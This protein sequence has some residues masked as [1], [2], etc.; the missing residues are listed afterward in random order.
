MRIFAA[1]F[2][3]TALNAQDSSLVQFNR[4]IRPLLSDRCFACHGPDPGNRKSPLRLDREAD[5]KA[6]LGK[7]RYGIVP[8]DPIRSGIYQRITSAN[9]G[10][11]MP[12]AYAGHDALPAE[13]IA[14]IKR[15][16]EQGAPYQAHYSFI[17]P[18]RPPIP[19]A[20]RNAI[21]HFIQARLQREGLAPAPPAD[22]RTLMRRVTLDL[23]GLPPTPAEMESFL[24]DPS[25][26][27]YEKV[28]DRL[29]ASPRYAERMAIRW[30]EAARYADTNGYQSDGTRDMWRWRDWVIDAFRKNMPFDQF[31]VEQ[32]A[33]DLLPNA[34]LSQRIATG[35]QRNHRT[36]AEGGI[37]DE[38]F[39]VEYV[40]DRTETTSTV[41]LGLTLGCARCHDHKFDPLA[42]KD[43]YSMFAFYNNVP[44]RGFVWN[45]G[46]E[47][48][49]I[50]APSPAEKAKLDQ[51]D[52]RIAQQRAKV[53]ALEPAIAKA[54]A[55]WAVPDKIWQVND[56]L[57]LESTAGFACKGQ[58]APF[59]GQSSLERILTKDAPDKPKFNNQDPFTFAAWIRPEDGKGAILSRAEDEWEGQQHGLYVVDGKLRL[60]IVFRWSDLGSRVETKLPLKL[61]QWQH[62]SA[63]YDGGMR[64][65]GIHLYVDGIEQPVNVL[66]D[67]LVWPIENK[68]PWRIGAGASLRF[69][70]EIEQPL[71]YSRALTSEEAGTLPLKQTLA[72]LVALKTK[73]AQS[74]LRMAFLELGLP[75]EL[76]RER[77]ALFSLE[78]ERGKY[79]ETVPTVM[80]M[81]EGATRQA[82]VLKRGAYDQHGEPVSPAI[83]A[84]LPGWQP[85]WPKNRLGLARWIVSRQNPLTARVTVNR[86]WQML[87]GTGIVKTVEDFGSQ[88]EWPLHMELLDWLA[89]EFMENGWDTKALLKTIVTSD[90]YR[91]SS[92]VSP[93]LLA[94]DPENRL[95]ARGTRLRISPEMVRDQALA[96]SGLLVDRVGG[97]SVKPYQP[98]GLWQEL[99]GGKGYTPDAG[100]GLYRRSLYT[101]WKRTIAP[102]GMV[103]FD[104]PTR[105]L[106]IVREG[107]TN[108]PLQALNLMN[109]V[110]YLEA[111]RKLAERML[112]AS[113]AAEGRLTYAYQATLGRAPKAAELT[114]LMRTLNQF[115]RQYQQDPQAAGE[116][117][118]QGDSPRDP[119]WQAPELAAY[120]ALAS[121]ILNLDEVVTKE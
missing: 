71:I 102:P 62:V 45:F 117:L 120:T 74:K 106:C 97:P 118:K 104:S 2:L 37:I 86:Y 55:A 57:I 101:Y 44:E 20:A 21:D 22:A 53:A 91:Q 78:R 95:F 80:V 58:C 41:W 25:T 103:N 72:Q 59:D 33:G 67:N 10:Q 50:K 110:L 87:F 109:D 88:G 14:L 96:V 42:Q 51:L 38:E 17:A 3:T 81:Q 75:T 84:S 26:G 35:F 61:H 4:Q 85:E 99:I 19:A 79:L 23:T 56:G 66:F 108:T 47:P 107:R 100:E 29:L 65:A 9:K 116:F 6:D 105:E 39:R 48:P 13:Q 73:A 1:L 111:S 94:R 27:A 16:I 113:P 32:L 63:T 92:H 12:P 82:Y 52:D 115:E 11:R 28:V 40:A 7:G 49:Y 114:I 5:A 83:P 36:T 69:K 76:K 98:P 60:H 31:T 121:L 8:G 24:A 30:L 54:Q 119:K 15:W 89:V 93:G 112:S 90:T 18:Q 43:F 34:T 46:N 68:Y 64:A 77:E 70:G